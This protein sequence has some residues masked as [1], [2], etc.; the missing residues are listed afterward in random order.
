MCL[1]VGQ[2]LVETMIHPFGIHRTYIKASREKWLVRL[3]DP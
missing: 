3:L 1:C 2:R